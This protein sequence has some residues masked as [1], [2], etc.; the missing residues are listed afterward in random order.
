METCQITVVCLVRHITCHPFN[1]AFSETFQFTK[2]MT[3]AR[4]ACLC[5]LQPERIRHAES[6]ESFFLL[7]P[8]RIRHAE[9]SE[10]FFLLQPERTRHAESS[11][12]FFLLQPERIRHAESSESFFLLQPERIRHAES[13]ES[14]GPVKT[15]GMGQE[16]SLE[17]Q[18]QCTCT[19]LKYSTFLCPILRKYIC[20][21]R[22]IAFSAILRLI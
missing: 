15:K 19:K 4:L 6:S 18:S 12:S 17:R 21:V 8:E 10:S 22:K 20:Q 5:L 11:E 3:L 14:N 13:S 7:Q 16:R 2:K 1:S 9:S